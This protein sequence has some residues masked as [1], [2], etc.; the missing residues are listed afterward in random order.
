M[1]TYMSK[2]HPGMVVFH[3]V[4]LQTGPRTMPTNTDSEV[5]KAF[6]KMSFNLLNF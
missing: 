5:L 2:W 1:K 3:H 6:A 4:E